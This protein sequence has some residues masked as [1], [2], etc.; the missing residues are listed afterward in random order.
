[1][2]GV[3]QSVNHLV[4]QRHYHKWSIHPTEE[5]LTVFAKPVS[6]CRAKGW[7]VVVLTLVN[8]FTLACSIPN[9]CVFIP[10]CAQTIVCA[11]AL[12]NWQS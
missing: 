7:D 9:V 5:M 8:H 12:S 11:C 10:T 1:M 6:F 2:V 3:K 4:F